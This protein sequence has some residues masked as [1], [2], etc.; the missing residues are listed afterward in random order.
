MAATL[1]EDEKEQK[2]PK[3]PKPAGKSAKKADAAGSGSAQSNELQFHYKFEP[4]V[5]ESSFG[6]IVAKKAGLD[7]RVLEIASRKAS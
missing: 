2:K 3:S 5:A 7:A 6:I 1:I 4:G